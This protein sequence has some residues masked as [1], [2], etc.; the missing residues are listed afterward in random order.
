MCLL[1]AVIPALLLAL[2]MLFLHP[3]AL[4]T[5]SLNFRVTSEL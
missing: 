1:L 3:C 2:A 4:T 5:N